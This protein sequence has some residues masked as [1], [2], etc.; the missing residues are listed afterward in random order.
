MASIL[1]E[2]KVF[3]TVQE[4]RLSFRSVDNAVISSEEKSYTCFHE[5][6]DTRIIYHISKV[7][8]RSKIMIQA[9]DTDILVILLGNMH[10]LN[11]KTIF[12][13]SA[14]NK[15]DERQCLNCTELAEV[16]GQDLCKALPGFQAFTGC[17]DTAAFYRKG[18]ARSFKLMETVKAFTNAFGSLLHPDVLRN[19]K[20]VNTIQEFTCFI[21]NIEETD[22]VD[23]A[24]FYMFNKRYASKRNQERLIRKVK[25]FH[26]SFVPPRWKS[27]YQKLLRT[28]F[29]SLMWHNATS[30][31][32][33][34]FDA[35]ENGW[36]VCN[37]KL[38]PRWFEGDPTPLAV[39][40]VL[41]VTS[42]TNEN[43]D[44]KISYEEDEDNCT[45][46]YECEQ[47]RLSC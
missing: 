47:N 35:T 30:I 38:R 27:L 20:V 45:S 37:N 5:E 22:D 19:Q 31:K 1:N 41:T 17:D 6:A 23:K 8:P 36:E 43:D 24:R 2:K 4:R 3:L 44:E 11:D 14:F 10:N 25:G 18:K 42:E 15:N 32:C 7:K 46:D 9:T 39:E 26:S 34:L 16:F 40:D 33:T 28:T 21:Y 13:A 12:I 29:V